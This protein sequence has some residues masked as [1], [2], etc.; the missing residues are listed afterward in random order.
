MAA[1]GGVASLVATSLDPPTAL[2]ITGLIAAIALASMASIAALGV[3][4][5]N[6]RLEWV[7]SW[8]A[9]TALAPYAL[10]YWYTVF[11]ENIERM[12]SAFLLTA[13]LGFFVTRA[14]M[15]SAHAERL[16]LLH[17]GDTG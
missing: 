11:T 17:E 5:N 7:A 6:Y 16:R 2:T 1:C 14:I 13:L 4:A 9:A 15:C 3:A 10:V 12:S 8:F